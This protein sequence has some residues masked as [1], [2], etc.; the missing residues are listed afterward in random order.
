MHPRDSHEQNG[1]VCGLHWPIQSVMNSVGFILML[2]YFNYS[3]NMLIIID[4]DSE[5][6]KNAFKWVLSANYEDCG[7]H[8]PTGNCTA[9]SSIDNV[10]VCYFDTQ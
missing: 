1:Y 2:F 8:C 10:S 3:A 7:C 5:E 9:C 6:H 4:D